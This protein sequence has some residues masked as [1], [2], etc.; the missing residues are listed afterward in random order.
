MPSALGGTVSRLNFVNA[1]CSGPRA[2]SVVTPGLR[3]PVEQKP[4]GPRLKKRPGWDTCRQGKPEVRRLAGLN[5]AKALLR[6]SHNLETPE[7]D[8]PDVQRH[9][10][11]E[12][13]RIAAKTPYPEVVAQN[14]GTLA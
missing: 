2:C 8:P 12:N 11:A 14:G 7:V 13:G 6:H 1:A 3:L 10:L 9:L 4:I 5:P